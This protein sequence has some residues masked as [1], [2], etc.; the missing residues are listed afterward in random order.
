MIK[1][2]LTLTLSLFMAF[3]LCL[4]ISANSGDDANSIVEATI[5]NKEGSKEYTSFL[6]GAVTK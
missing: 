1:K 6:E 2:I 3:S 5:S 4:T